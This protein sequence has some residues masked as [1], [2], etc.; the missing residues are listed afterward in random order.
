VCEQRRQN[1]VFNYSGNALPRVAARQR[2]LRRQR[3]VCERGL[4][5]SA[6]AAAAVMT[7][8]SR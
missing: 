6:A 3:A 7:Q 1:N 5:L 2:A 8:S 4:M